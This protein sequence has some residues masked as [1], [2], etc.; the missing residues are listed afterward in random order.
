MSIL[1]AVVI[2]IGVCGIIA[3]LINR[4]PFIEAEFKTLGVYAMLVVAVILIAMQLWP[5][6]PSN[7][8]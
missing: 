3:F 8:G 2:I 6:I 5:L 1:I 7:L 4:A